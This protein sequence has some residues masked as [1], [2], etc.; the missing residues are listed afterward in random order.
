MLK[1]R[2]MMMP[3]LVVYLGSF[4]AGSRWGAGDRWS[5]A[6]WAPA[7]AKSWPVAEWA[8]P[9]RADGSA[10][11]LRD[12][13]ENPLLG[14]REYMLNLYRDRYVAIKDWVEALDGEGPVA[15]CCWCPYTRVAKLQI[16]RFGTYH[17]HLD[18]VSHVLSSMEVEVRWFKEP[19]TMLRHPVSHFNRKEEG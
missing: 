11:K 5:G 8:Q 10:I 19:H 16:E 9:L 14:Y 6:R 4:V 13:G 1:K 18:V 7:W 15:L 2:R 12:F 17:C 3:D